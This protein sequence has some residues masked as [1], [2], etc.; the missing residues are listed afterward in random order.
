MLEAYD[1]ILRRRYGD[2][3]KLPPENARVPK[4]NDKWYW[5]NEE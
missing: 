5:K 4:G 1:A 2:Y 3:M